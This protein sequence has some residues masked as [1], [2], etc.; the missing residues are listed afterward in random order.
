MVPVT[1]A[2]AV[3]VVVLGV[4]LMIGGSEPGVSEIVDATATA[5][6]RVSPREAP[7]DPDPAALAPAPT[8]PLAE[9][10]IE[11]D[12]TAAASTTNEA[13]AADAVVA[14]TGT[15]V[16]D[17]DSPS[18]AD[19]QARTVQFTAPRG[20]RIIWT[21]DPNFESPIAGQEPRQEQS[22]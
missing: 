17:I 2:A 22:R 7:L 5:P 14:T 19:K 6:D 12:P 11:P 21:L 1:V 4:S 3:T 15:A 16:A 13:I 9:S 20:T 8:G 10:L 18:P